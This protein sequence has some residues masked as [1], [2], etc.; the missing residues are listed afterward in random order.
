MRDG[1]VG[2][3]GDRVALPHGE[4]KTMPPIRISGRLRNSL[5]AVFLLSTLW[6]A[7]QGQPGLA[8]TL[9]AAD[10]SEISNVTDLLRL[11]L[12]EADGGALMA[13]IP[14][15]IARHLAER[16]GLSFGVFENRFTSGFESA[17]RPLDIVDARFD[18]DAATVGTTEGGAPY[19]LIPTETIMRSGSRGRYRFAS[20][21]L[22][23]R[24][25]GLWYL[26]QL[27][28][29]GDAELVREV[30]PDFADVALEVAPAITVQ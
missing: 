23:L 1:L 9:S 18:L 27:T 2:R 6:L 21:T 16:A 29:A 3:A 20:Q 14:P 15:A 5:R 25:G 4:R 24:D 19:A 13:T 11:A 12:V 10:R 7:V 17:I 8:Q 22:A 30:Y 26:V 28:E